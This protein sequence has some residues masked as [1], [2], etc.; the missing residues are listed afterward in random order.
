MST[1]FCSP[2]R[3]PLLSLPGTLGASSQGGGIPS[4]CHSIASASNLCLTYVL[5]PSPRNATLQLPLP[6]FTVSLRTGLRNKTAE[7]FQPHTGPNIDMTLPYE[8]QPPFR[9]IK[10]KSFSSAS[11]PTDRFVIAPIPYLPRTCCAASGEP[12]LHPV[13]GCCSGRCSGN[14][15]GQKQA[16][17]RRP[18]LCRDPGTPGAS[19]RCLICE[20]SARWEDRKGCNSSAGSQHHWA[21]L[22]YTKQA[23]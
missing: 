14:H 20:S 19:D 18:R 11:P 23:G 8:V 6:S 10:V 7:Y 12:F 2:P 13:C 9:F 17:G 5:R 16:R 4:A 21:N 3:A 1:A 22:H 15:H